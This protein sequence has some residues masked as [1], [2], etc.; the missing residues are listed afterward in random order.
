MVVDDTFGI[1]KYVQL[2]IMQSTGTYRTNKRGQDEI[3]MVAGEG[4]RRGTRLPEIVSGATC[5]P[6][7]TAK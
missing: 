5:R 7:E 2:G 6:G 3:R 1:P 4:Q